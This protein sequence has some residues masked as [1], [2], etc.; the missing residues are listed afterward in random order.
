MKRNTKWM[1]LVLSVALLLSATACSQKES[2]A[3]TEKSDATVEETE[4]V[5][6]T[7]ETTE[8][9]TEATE[10]EVEETEAEETEPEVEV[11]DR[12]ARANEW[13]TMLRAK[14]TEL[15]EADSSMVFGFVDVYSNDTA[16]FKLATY[17]DS[18]G[19]KFYA[20]TDGEVQEAVYMGSIEEDTKPSDF[21]MPYEQFMDFPGFYDFTFVGRDSGAFDMSSYEKTLADGYYSGQIFGFSKDCTYAYMKVGHMPKVNLSAEEC[22]NLNVGDTVKL[23]GVSM[24]VSGVD[25]DLNYEGQTRITLGDI[26]NGGMFITIDT[27]DDGNVSNF[28]VLSAF[29]YTAIEDPHLVKVPVSAEAIIEIDDSLIAPSEVQKY[30]SDNA[31]TSLLYAEYSEGGFAFYTGV[32]TGLDLRPL[33]IE[34]GEITYIAFNAK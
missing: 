11:D 23:D 13:Y 22:L 17:S 32:Y 6:T 19:L 7:E 4:V 15:H 16:V 5:D 34:N 9:T 2:P 31:V 21:L 12:A 3:E 20:V 8:E 10:T 26:D 18:E 25:Y 33:K 28:L 1:S 14:A 27:D 24:E 30:L 29:G